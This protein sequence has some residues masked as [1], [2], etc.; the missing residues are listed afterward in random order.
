[1]RECRTNLLGLK[2]NGT[3]Q[4]RGR[5]TSRKAPQLGAA[6]NINLP[7]Q[8]AIRSRCQLVK[9][10]AF[11]SPRSSAIFAMMSSSRWSRS[12]L[13]VPQS[14]LPSGKSPHIGT[15]DVD[16]GLAVAILDQ[17]RYHE[18]CKRLQNAGLKPD[19]NEAGSSTNQRWRIEW[20]PNVT[21]DFLIPATLDMT[22]AGDSEILRKELQRSLRRAWN[23]HLPTN[24]S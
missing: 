14:Q 16:L 15:M 8:K 23:W 7:L 11:T 9:P 18:L 10:R 4:G 6:W 19:V 1:M 12:E 24:G 22:K 20:K 17:Q 2:A 21:V 13:I 5:G 3:G